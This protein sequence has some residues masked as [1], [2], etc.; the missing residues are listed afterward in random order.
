[1]RHY[2]NIQSTYRSAAVSHCVHTSMQCQSRITLQ[3]KPH[4][5]L[6]WR[7]LAPKA[8]DKQQNSMSISRLESSSCRVVKGTRQPVCS[9]EYLSDK[10]AAFFSPMPLLLAYGTMG[11]EMAIAP[12]WVKGRR[13]MT[14]SSKKRT[15]LYSEKCH[16]SG[17]P[18][19]CCAAS[20]GQKQPST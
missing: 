15:D 5:R 2:A 19:T 10:Q 9:G 13:K 4:G 14:E 20:K 3:R 1:M 16:M 8:P 7:L 17:K 6:K 18:N 11:I 12:L